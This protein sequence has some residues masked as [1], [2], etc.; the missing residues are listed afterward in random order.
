[1]DRQA[2]ARR[3]F[4][5]YDYFAFMLALIVFLGFVGYTS[6]VDVRS[7]LQAMAGGGGLLLGLGV[8]RFLQ[9]RRLTYVVTDQRVVVDAGLVWRRTT[10][11][12]LTGLAA[13]VVLPER[14][15]A[16]TITFGPVEPR[17]VAAARYGAHQ[18]KSGPLPVV[19]AGITEPEDVRALLAKAIAAARG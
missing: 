5:R 19:L 16:G 8:V 11:A 2:G 15:G 12:R 7:A 13:P 3:L 18:N 10:T 4:N 6:A 9:L 17:L 14:G 1:V